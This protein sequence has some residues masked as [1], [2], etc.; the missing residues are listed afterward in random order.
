MGYQ[1]LTKDRSLGFVELSVAELA[2]QTEDERVPY[3]GTGKRDVADPI[4]LGKGQTKGELHYT[5]EFIPALA[6]QG[7]SFRSVDNIQRTIDSAKGQTAATNTEKGELDDETPLEEHKTDGVQMS[8]EELLSKQ[9]GVLVFN[10]IDGHIAKKA[11]LEILL[12]DGYWPVFATE[13]ARSTQAHWDQVGEGFIKELDFGRVWLRL[14]ENDEGEKE[15]IIAEF[16]LDA[17]QFLEEALAGPTT[18]NLSGQDGKNASTIR[19]QAK[20]VPVEIK[21][22]PRE[23]INNVGVLHVELV[24]GR[25]IHG[26]DRSGKSDPFVVF[27]LN[28]SKVF[29]SQTKK[30]TLTPEWKESFD[31]SIPSRVGA[32]FSLEV[33]DWNQVEAAKS[34]GSGQVELSDL[35]PLE[36][37]VREIALSSEKHGEN[38]I[39]QIYMVFRPKIIVKSRAKTSTFPSAGHVV[40]RKGRKVGGHSGRDG[41]IPE[42]LP[43][44]SPLAP[45]AEADPA[46][47][48]NGAATGRAGS[49]SGLAVKPP[50]SPTPGPGILKVTL[51]WAKVL[52]GIKEG[53]VAKL[54]VILRIE[55][56]S[57]KSS[58]VKSNTPEWNESFTFPNTSTEIR[59]LHVAVMDKKTF[60]KDPILAEGTIDIWQH[61]QP[62]FTPPILSKEITVLLEDNSGTLHLRLEFDPIQNTLA[63]TTSTAGGSSLTVSKKTPSRSRLGFNNRWREKI[64]TPQ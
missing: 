27:Y 33:F 46:A 57:H 59:T 29:K 15:D 12:D 24:D 23:S 20:Y 51:H 10:I 61:I 38:G 40:G 39:I 7:V 31:I 26:A 1:R 50:P 36:V 3:E 35:V 47:N 52:T 54:Y 18:F 34:L 48:G 4:R 28:G 63:H 64:I 2:R 22:D 41:D 43:E 58:H 62:L 37:T 19:I 60:A 25:E 21:L 9:S 32:D 42:D 14:N 55:D 45:I 44:V 6:L 5:A 13:K 17:K 49:T 53:D 16:K 11:R 30:K 56:K 8:T